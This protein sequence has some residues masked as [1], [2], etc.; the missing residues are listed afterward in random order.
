MGEGSS[1]CAGA[2]IAFWGCRRPRRRS[3]AS[4]VG[5]AAV[6]ALGISLAFT[7]AAQATTSYNLKGALD[8]GAT[9]PLG[10]AVDQSNGH[11]FVANYANG[12]PSKSGVVQFEAS[13]SPVL[14]E[15]FAASETY[16]GVAVD[17]ENQ[18]VYAYNSEHQEINTF[19][20]SG[21][22]LRHFKVAGGQY[23]FVQIASNAG[24]YIYYPNQAEGSVQEFEPGAEG[25]SPTPV[26]TFE[27]VDEGPGKEHAL[28]EPRSVAVDSED[29][30]VYVVDS[31][32]GAG[33]VQVFNAETGS[34]ESTLTEGG[35]QDV[36]VDP[37][38]GDVFVL[39]RGAGG[40]Y[41]VAYHAGETTPFA[42]FG[43]GTIG[44]GELPFNHIAVDHSS[45]DV[46]VSDVGHHKVWIFAPGSPPPAVAYPTPSVTGLSASDTTLR[47]EVNPEGNDTS[48]HFE[49]G[50]TET[51]SA[52][53]PCQ[54][55][56]VGEGGTFEPEAVTIKGLEGNTEY[57]FRLVATAP[58]T[59]VTVHGADQTFTTSQAPPALLANSVFASNVTQSD[60]VFNATINP[61][62]LGTRYWFNYGLRPFEDSST[63]VPPG[64][65]PYASVPITPGDLAGPYSTSEELAGLPVETDL[66][67]ESVVLHPGMGSRELQPNTVYHFQ[68][69]AENAAVPGTSCE[70]EAT[71]ITLPPDPLAS[72]GAASAV[73]QTAAN[74]AGAVTPG[75]TGPNSDTTWRFEYGTSTSYTQSAPVK[76][77][78]GG[79][80]TSAVGVSTALEALAPNTT[81]HYRLVASNANE[82]P[83]AD[84]AVAP[85]TG[86]GADRTF[87]TLPTEPAL[88]QV[89][90]LSETGVTLNG[91]VSPGG[92][93]L[94]Y[95]FQYGPTT[96]YGQSTPLTDAGEGGASMDVTAS[97]TGL[98]PGTYHYRLVVVGIAGGESYS[99]DSTLSLYGPVPEQ[100]GNPFS[101]GHAAPVP[102]SVFPLL[103]T[104]TFPPPPKETVTPA[105]PLSAAQKLTKALKTCK[106]LKQKA[107]R[108]ACDKQ[109]H[110]R[111]G[112][113]AKKRTKT[114]ARTGPGRAQR[115]RSRQRAGRNLGE[116]HL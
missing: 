24:G 10:V 21:T 67:G 39:D 88:D 52:S 76:A 81:Y 18:N 7:P 27:G 40:Y 70:P 89:S 112:T 107:K 47:G 104:P 13:G 1:R 51:Y 25:A 68:V 43:E 65:V 87:T 110:H 4:L 60:V 63:C 105:K 22:E 84:P 34:Y 64:T 71:F 56:L 62:H 114:L 12:I 11:V 44:E 77:G 74:L 79:M 15:P 78:D 86:D 29:L 23:A 46:Y 103:S 93:H 75:S 98:A 91:S 14:P 30:K 57:H 101:P 9:Y 32:N 61:Q 53:V 99:P 115:H 72:T 96:E 2:E 102:F 95:S 113:A 90:G 80:G 6:C 38:N 100:S 41:V 37:V 69:V 45:G 85:Q 111:Y 97:L 108:I 66:A 35:S 94:H 54:P 19:E 82:D 26:A 5:I 28:V 16:A 83:A 49:Y 31:G 33:R 109:A 42:E 116:R 59:G 3:V 50:T 20:P 55:E 36:A 73:T 92:H 8:E 106:K 17:P 48:C 58:S